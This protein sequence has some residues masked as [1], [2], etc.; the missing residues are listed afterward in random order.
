MSNEPKIAAECLTPILYVRDFTEAMDYYTDK[1]LFDR[2]WDWGNPPEFGAVRLGKV[3]IFFCLGG[4]G[5]PGTW[6]SIFVDAVDDYFERI[7][8]LGAEVIRG[9]KDELWGVREMHVR[10]PNQHVIRFGHGIPM[11]EPKIEIERVPFETRIEKRLASLLADLARHKNMTLGEMLEEMFLH[12]FE[13]VPS[14]GVAS[15]HT[16]KTLSYIKA[17]KEKHGIDYD[18]H[19]SYRF[20]E[21]T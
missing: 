3:E 19:G 9:P 13:K 17:L 11:R 21:K 14:G 15:P 20:I 4:Q 10:D 8:R 12:S 16:E 5:H 7:T 1:L 6:L 2:L 18:T